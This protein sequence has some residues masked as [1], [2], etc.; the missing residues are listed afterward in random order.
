[1]VNIIMEVM[2]QEVSNSSSTLPKV[3]E[4]SNTNKVVRVRKLVKKAS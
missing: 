2:K 4:S 3:S 1:M